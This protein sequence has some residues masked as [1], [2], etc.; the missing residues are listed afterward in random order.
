MQVLGQ[1]IVTKKISGREA[2][3]LKKVLLFKADLPPQW[4][5]PLIQGALPLPL[6]P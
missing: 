2:K 3:I 5:G 1:V 6:L 4:H